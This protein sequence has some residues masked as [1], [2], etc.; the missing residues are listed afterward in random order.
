[1]DLGSIL[2]SG[3]VLMGEKLKNF[4]S[5]FATYCGVAHCMGVANGLDAISIILESFKYLGRL[6]DGDEI[7]VP[8]NTYIATIL[9]ITNAGLKP[10]L[11]EPDSLTY[12][13]DPHLVEQNISDKTKAIFTV[14]LYG[15]MSNLKILN[16]IA[17]K[18]NLYLFDDAVQAHGVEDDRRQKIEGLTDATAFSFYPGK[19]LEALGDGG[20]ITTNDDALAE[21]IL[22][23]RNYGSQEKYYNKYKG[24]NSRLDELQAAFLCHKLKNLDRDNDCRRKIAKRYLN[25]INH[26][27]IILPAYS[28]GKDHVFHL[29]IVRTKKRKKFMEFME[30]NGVQTAIHYPLPAHKQEAYAEWNNMSYPISEAIHEEV[31]SLPISLLMTNEEVNLVIETVNSFERQYK[32]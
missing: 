31:V 22:A 13:L 24:I 29:F 12:N 30:E 8:S 19:N 27:D 9:G 23:C 10:V 4:E 2:D 7:I 1:M 14:Y 20:A 25:E 3:W 21:I 5:A 15:H 6:E 18:Y 16:G 11:V 32:S 26:G 17:Q 28:G